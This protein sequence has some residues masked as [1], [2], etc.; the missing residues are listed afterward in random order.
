MKPCGYY[1]QALILFCYCS[2]TSWFPFLILINSTTMNIFLYKVLLTFILYIFIHDQAHAL[3]MLEPS[4]RVLPQNGILYMPNLHRGSKQ[5]FQVRGARCQV[6]SEESYRVDILAGS[7]EEF[8]LHSS[9]I[10]LRNF[11]FYYIISPFF[12]FIPFNTPP[13]LSPRFMNFLKKHFF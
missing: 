9:Y 2:F 7:T 8:S 1:I 12:S 5:V 11:Y 10:S 3:S 4:L 6:F 13:P